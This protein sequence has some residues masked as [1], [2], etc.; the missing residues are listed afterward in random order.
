MHALIYSTKC[1]KTRTDNMG[2]IPPKRN[3]HLSSIAD[4]PMLKIL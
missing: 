1:L 3:N 4:M 2:D